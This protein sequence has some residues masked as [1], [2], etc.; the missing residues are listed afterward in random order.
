MALAEEVKVDKE[1]VVKRADLLVAEAREASKV[2]APAKDFFSRLWTPL[3]RLMLDSCKVKVLPAETAVP[4][5]KAHL[6][7]ARA[8]PAVADLPAAAREASP[9]S[10]VSAAAAAA[11]AANAVVNLAARAALP[12]DLSRTAKRV[13]PLP[14]SFVA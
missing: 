13:Q 12:A 4:R 14:P 7:V 9:V 3:I 11:A 6:V 10:R 8:A 2:A 1:A 5:D